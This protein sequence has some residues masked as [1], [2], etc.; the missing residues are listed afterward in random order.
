M[1]STH[2]WRIR[3]AGIALL[4]VAG[5]GARALGE[6]TEPP[7]PV[8][9]MRPGTT[10]G[11]TIDGF[12][13]PN[14]LVEVAA[15]EAG[16]VASIAVREGQRVVAGQLL[17]TL[18][19][20][21]LE[22]SRAIA[23]ARVAARGQLDLAI[24]ERDVRRKRQE[25]LLQLATEGYARPDELDHAAA[26]V[27]VAVANCQ[28]AEEERQVARLELARIDALLA[29]RT[30]RSPLTG[31]VA[32]VLYEPSEFVPAHQP[33][34]LTLVELELLRVRFAVPWANAGAMAPGNWAELQAPDLKRNLAARIDFVSP[35]V[36]AESG[37][38]RVDVVIDNTA[39][40]IPCGVRCQWSV[41]ERLA[42][43]VSDRVSESATENVP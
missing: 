39:G 12:I 4:M 13:E 10:S 19:Q 34:L 25:K 33:K 24:A 18:D 6:A 35:V 37:T 3:A 29:Q 17:A 9:A 21:A 41:E 32:E 20:T 26:D 40:D 27:A 1:C 43:Q 23:E 28:A 38:V 31:I 15:A 30:V 2:R 5:R 14:R 8:A 11:A 7:A 22:A 42:S 16:V 36:D